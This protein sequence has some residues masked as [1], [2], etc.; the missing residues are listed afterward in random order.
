MSGL[1]EGK[2]YYVRAYAT[3]SVGT[4]Y[5]DFVSFTTN[6]LRDID[7]NIYHNVTIGTQVWLVEDLKTTHFRDGTSIPLVS[8]GATWGNLSTPAYCWHNNNIANKNT[9]G[10]LYNWYTVNTGKLAPA[11]WHVPTDSEWFTLIN[12]LGGVSKAG[13]K[14]KE[15]GTTHWLSPNTGAT[16]ETGFSALPCGYRDESNGIFS[17]NGNLGY[18]VLWWS[19]TENGTSGGD[20][21]IDYLYTNANQTTLPKK[22]GISV[23][24]IKD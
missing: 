12:Y 9:Y 8:D 7:G 1:I 19:T 3:N 15:A 2:K 13:P 11:G 5:G 10:A 22:Y 23:R 17:N 21:G 20:V 24:C 18:S 6:D 16:N 4:S 14:L